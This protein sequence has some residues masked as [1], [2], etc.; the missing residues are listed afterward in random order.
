MDT[1]K[2]AIADLLAGVKMD[3]HFIPFSLSRSKNK[4]HQDI[5]YVI[6]LS[7]GKFSFSCDYSMGIAYV[8]D[9]DKK[10]AGSLSDK[11]I[12][13]IVE[14]GTCCFDFYGEKIP[15]CANQKIPLS[16]K[17]PDIVDVFYSLISDMSYADSSFVD[18]CYELGFND[19]SIA[20]K[21]IY[22][23]VCE[24]SRNVKK[25]LSAKTIEKLQEAYQDY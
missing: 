8:V 2:Q 9:R 17:T 5:N 14:T 18:W 16:A 15:G 25:L 11:Q 6:A 13:V 3:Y 4:T 24:N 23:Q 10:P 19:D 22:D 1:K 21:T 20:E 12:N 7:N